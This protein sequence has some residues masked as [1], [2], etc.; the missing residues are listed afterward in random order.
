MARTKYIRRGWHKRVEN[1]PE[2]EEKSEGQDLYGL[3]M[4]RM[5]HGS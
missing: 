4:Q 2:G 1:K 3:M 5:I